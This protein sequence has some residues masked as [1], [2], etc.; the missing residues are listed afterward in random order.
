MGARPADDRFYPLTMRKDLRMLAKRIVSMSLVLIMLFAVTTLANGQKTSP[1]G[2]PQKF[3]KVFVGKIGDKYAIHMDLNRS[4]QNFN[5]SYYY[6]NV[7]SGIDVE[8]T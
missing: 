3:N 2:I 7:G 4:D 6:D 8:G 1:S 5:G